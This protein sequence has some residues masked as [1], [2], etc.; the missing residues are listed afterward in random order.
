MIKPRAL[1]HRWTSAPIEW[2]PCQRFTSFVLNVTHLVLPPG[3]LWFCRLFNQAL[4]LIND[5]AL[6]SE[7]KA[8]IAQEGAHAKGHRSVLSCYESEGWNFTESQLRLHYLFNVMLGDAVLGKWRVRGPWVKRWLRM[9]IGM[10]AALEHITC[11]LGNWVIQNHALAE[12]NANPRM[13]NLLRWHGAEEVEHRTVAFDVYRH[14]GGS[15]VSR[16]L[17]FGPVLGV[18]LLTW[19]RGAQV[20]FKQ[21]NS[22]PKRYGFRAYLKASNEGLLP[23]VGYL[24]KHCLRYLKFNYHPKTEG[25]YELAEGILK[26]FE[27]S[28]THT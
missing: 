22:G 1:F 15:Y 19:K 26:E 7:V 14:L 5:P 27:L 21:D 6:A 17:W 23:S 25:N 18:L 13:L 20:F 4:P 28:K 12:N 8:F 9:R 10:I 16:V 2:V 3:E 11:I 24:T